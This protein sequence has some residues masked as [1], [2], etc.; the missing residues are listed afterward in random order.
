[1]NINRNKTWRSTNLQALEEKLLKEVIPD[2]QGAVQQPLTH[3]VPM[4]T[5]GVR[6]QEVPHCISD[7]RQPFQAFHVDQETSNAMA[8]ILLTSENRGGVCQQ[9]STN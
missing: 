4:L 9:N 3:T 8:D 7:G 5:D 1:M 6:G 2:R